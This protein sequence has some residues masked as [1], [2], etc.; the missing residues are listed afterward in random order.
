MTLRSLA[1][2]STNWAAFR[3]QVDVESVQFQKKNI[4]N[5]QWR[6]IYLLDFFFAIDLKEM[7][8]LNKLN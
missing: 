2:P 3:E 7:S 1:V 8:K 5:K 4:Y 6:L